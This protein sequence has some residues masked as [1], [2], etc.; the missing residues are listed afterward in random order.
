MIDNLISFYEQIKSNKIS[1]KNV[2][3]VAVKDVFKWWW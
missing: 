2:Q 1:N 3:M